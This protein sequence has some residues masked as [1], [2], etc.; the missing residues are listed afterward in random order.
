MWL[1]STHKYLLVDSGYPCIQWLLTPYLNPANAP[2]MN[3][4]RAHKYRDQTSK[5][6]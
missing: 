6:E 5:E 4:N 3:Y 2:Q 1:A